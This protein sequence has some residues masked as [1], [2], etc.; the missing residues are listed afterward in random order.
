MRSIF[1]TC[2]L[3][4]LAACQG[5][6]QEG[7]IAVVTS[8]EPSPR[9]TL[10][11]S[12]PAPAKRPQ[13]QPVI[14]PLPPKPTY[15]DTT[16][17]AAVDAAIMAAIEQGKTPG[18]VLWIERKGQ[19]Y[20]KAFGNRS[21]VPTKERTTL[22]TIYDLASLTK[23]IATAPSIV[24]LH[25]QGKLSVHDPVAK[26]LPEF[27]VNNKGEVTILNLLTHSSGL[28]PGL[29][30][31]PAWVGNEHAIRLACAESLRTQPGTEFKY[32]DINYILL[33]QIV[34]EVSGIPLHEFARREI[35]NPLQMSETDYLPRSNKQARIAPT[36]T[37]DTGVIRGVVHDPTSS[38]MGG[39]AGHAGLFS[40][41]SDLARFARML[42]NRGR[43]NGKQILSP[44]SINLMTSN[45]SP[46]A[47][48]HQ[49]GLGWDI[50]SP[51]SSPRGHR[52][53]IGSFGHTGWTGTSIWIDPFSE[54]F[55]I[56]LANRNHP[57]EDG[58][59]IALRRTI[60][61]LTA[62]ALIGYDF[63]KKS[64]ARDS[65][66]KKPKLGVNSSN[67]IDVLKETQFKALDGMAIGLITN[68][69]G[70]SRE[71]ESTIDLL[72]QSPT[73]SL[74]ALFS[75]EH[76]I[77]GKEDSQVSDSRDTKTGL[78][79]FS[80]YGTTR[81]PMPNHLE[82]IDALVFDIQDIGCRFYTY[83][84][85]M[86]LAMEA[87]AEAEI[88]FIVLDRINPITG[89]KVEGPMLTGK[90]SF[91]GYHPIPVRHGMT[92]GELAQLFKSEKSLNLDLEVIPVTNWKRALW[93]DETRIPWINPS[94]NMRSLTQATLYPG[95]GLLEMA[96][97]SVGRG[98]STP[99]ELLGAPYINA[100]KL[101]SQIQQLNL[102]G[103]QVTPVHYTPN[104]SKFANE[105]CHGVQFQ[106]TDRSQFRPITL[107]LNIARILHQDYPA[108]FELTKVNRL[109]INPEAIAQIRQGEDIS[110]I[111]A[112][113]EPALAEFK[114]RRQ[115][116]LLYE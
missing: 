54:T 78:P 57:T 97:L 8:Q 99:F 90:T 36:T 43:L 3:V 96:D 55:V 20:K 93:L 18:G 2:F 34:H 91:I 26:H 30:L 87:A 66:P 69:T 86:G 60:G 106:I 19:S 40:T 61:T 14:I 25:E 17:L 107:G 29:S 63:P 92:V 9:P 109:L 38:R 116:H 59:V 24:K 73:V 12:V 103:I 80:L 5:P 104:A 85:T 1:C 13:D 15:L 76:G 111:F 37:T 77:R 70:K 23:V 6:R 52:F 50:A 110:A 108:Q 95:I 94:P 81:K 4:L 112:A 105:L 42:L 53:E 100:D 84:S 114:K 67:G 74:K 7:P 64:P 33:G 35:Y 32:S 51:Y 46:T 10:G 56:F 102:P 82:G 47:I 49:R 101:A 31:S 65:A 16:K 113:W 71:G 44:A 62:D 22:D 28:R 48:Q 88:K 75:P 41:A 98:T 45:Q 115:S 27:A 39:V 58:S 83:I 68:H 21:L 89:S 79:I 72:H 11:T